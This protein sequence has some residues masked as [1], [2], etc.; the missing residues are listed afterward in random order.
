MKRLQLI[1][2]V[3]LPCLSPPYSLVRVCMAPRLSPYPSPSP[4][5]C[6]ALIILPTPPTPPTPPRAPC[7]LLLSPCVLPVQVRMALTRNRLVNERLGHAG[8][9]RVWTLASRFLR[10]TLKSG[11]QSVADWLQVY[12]CLSLSLSLCLPVCLSV[13]LS[14]CLSV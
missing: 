13:C 4:F 2:G 1:I 11:R 6:H 5:P 9:G 3:S 8:P 7:L 10:V 14:L 12:L